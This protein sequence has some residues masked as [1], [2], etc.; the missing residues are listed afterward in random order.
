[1]AQPGPKSLEQRKGNSLLLRRLGS[2]PRPEQLAPV[3]AAD[4]LVLVESAL[5][6]M[7]KQ[8][9]ACITCLGQLYGS[10][11]APTPI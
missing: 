1:M 5:D 3:L 9:P 6:G 8:G 2:G 10:E 4:P 11:M 7:G